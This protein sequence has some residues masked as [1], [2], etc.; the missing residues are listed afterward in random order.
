MLDRIQRY[1]PSSLENSAEKTA[2]IGLAGCVS[3]ALI[4]IASSQI[5]LA[6]V[7]V[8]SVFM[9]SFNK[10]SF[11]LMRRI[12][13]PL[14]IFFAWTILTVL[15]AYNI[16]L[17]LTSI[18]KFYLF[19]IIPIV[20]LIA[21]GQNRLWWIY[22]AI[23]TVAVFSSTVGIGQF[24][25]N[26][27]APNPLQRMFT[28]IS[29]WWFFLPL[30][31]FCLWTM[32]CFLITLQKKWALTVCNKLPLALLFPLVPLFMRRQKG[33]SPIYAAIFTVALISSIVGIS[34]R[35]TDIKGN[36]LLHR[37]CGLVSHWMTYS[38]L[39]MLA[40]ILLIAYGIRAKWRR[41]FL[42]VP[43]AALIS[44]AIALSLTRNTMLGVYI[45]IF[46]IIALALFLE[47]KKR[48]IIFFMGYILFSAVLYFSAPASMKQRFRSGLDPEDTTTRTRIE[49]AD[50][51]VRMI[52]DNLW[53][54]LGGP[55]N[56]YEEALKYRNHNEFPDW[57]YQ[58]M[59]DNFLQIAAEK[60]I[61]G[62]LI[63]L[64][65]MVQFAWDSLRTYRFARSDSFPLG[66]ESRW[67]ATLVSS[68][69]LGS[70]AAL[71]I[72]GLFEY[73]FGDSEVLT[74]FLFIMSAP[75][76]YSRE[77]TETMA[78]SSIRTG[79]SNA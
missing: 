54:G 76:A 60:G 43:V 69:A 63:W 42:W 1:L 13:L 5:L 67:E 26:T 32:V 59:H 30:S 75:Y 2:F 61:P 46:V 44:L 6:V 29:H 36:D 31:I 62:L 72:A 18:K 37:I 17:A 24:F 64:W 56:V 35:F 23:F 74:L 3:L 19:L 52:K 20:P 10:E 21:R 11:S 9:P 28:F 40:L 48:F 47:K 16:P 73:N 12:L 50:T 79:I 51:S 70:W 38:G 4:S 25:L 22:K 45:G 49:L 57:L 41:F 39:L 71:M 65:L 53:F 8:A 66:E 58:H 34:L 15:M 78:K 7:L 68:A 14:V 77:I 27:Q 55:D 33:L